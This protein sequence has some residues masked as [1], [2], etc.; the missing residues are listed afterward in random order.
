MRRLTAPQAFC[1]GALIALSISAGGPRLPDGAD[2]GALDRRLSALERARPPVPGGRGAL[3]QRIARL[4]Q[5]YRSEAQAEARTTPWGSPVQGGIL[6]SPASRSRFHPILHQ[7]RPHT[8]V[9][10][11]APVGAPIHATADGVATSR[12][13][14]PT[15]GVGVD[16]DHGRGTITRYAHMQRAAVRL[17]QHIVRGDVIGYV[18]STGRATGPH[19]HYEVFRRWRRVDPAS[20]LPDDLAVAASPGGA[21][22]F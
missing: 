8:G 15:Y 9:D 13:D 2:D 16:V 20:F 12:F 18:G 22:D 11:A 4:E 21:G 10:I 17:G 6:T 19:V 5:A 1:V 3:L 14:S 7:F